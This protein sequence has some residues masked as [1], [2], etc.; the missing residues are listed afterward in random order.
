M[1]KLLSLFLLALVCTA[2]TSKQVLKTTSP[3]VAIHNGYYTFENDKVKLVYNLWAERGMFAFVLHNKLA[4]PLYI[5]WEKSAFYLNGTYV[6]YRSN[7]P[8]TN[9][10]ADTTGQA[11]AYNFAWAE[12]LMGTTLGT[13]SPPTEAIT[14]LQPKAMLAVAKYRLIDLDVYMGG[15]DYIKACEEEKKTAKV[16]MRSYTADNTPFSFSNYLLFSNTPTFEQTDTLLHDFWVNEIIRS[17]N[18]DSSPSP[19][20]TCPYNPHTSYYIRMNTGKY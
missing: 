20:M 5:N 6:D 17:N 7:T 3:N 10:N 9:P 8:A 15:A 13:C 2:Y 12:R 4:E 19:D 14:A 11:N 18:F 16:L 1:I